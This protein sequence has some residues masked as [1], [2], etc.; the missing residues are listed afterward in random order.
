MASQVTQVLTQYPLPAP[1]I[2]DS[3]DVFSQRAFSKAANDVVLVTQIN[4]L[5]SQMNT[6]ATDVNTNSNTATNS[7]TSATNSATSATNSA[8]SATNSATSAANSATAAANS[9]TSAANSATAAANVVS[10]G[11]LYDGSISTTQT[12]SSSKVN[13]YMTNLQTQ[14]NSLTALNNLI[15]S[16]L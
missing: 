5:V 11:V 4:T 15:Y 7:A 3:Q 12:W 10:Q 1:Q 8:T 16:G 13:S 6:V 2:T 9:A 14:I